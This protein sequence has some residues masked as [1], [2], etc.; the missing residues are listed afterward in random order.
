MESLFKWSNMQEMMAYDAYDALHIIMGVTFIITYFFKKIWTDSIWA[1]DFYSNSIRMDQSF[2]N[3]DVLF[4][5]SL[6]IVIILILL[7]VVN[8][9]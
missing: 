2:L 7:I 1:D 6:C 4:I 9:E 3:R 5:L 8:D